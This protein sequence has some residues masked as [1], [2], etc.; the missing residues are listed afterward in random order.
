M[1]ADPSC[2][3]DVRAAAMRQLADW[4]LEETAFATEL[5]LSELVTNA[6]RY[7][8]EPIRVRLIFDRS[9]ICE[10][11][12]GSSTAPRL[13]QAA[14]TDEGGRGLFLVA[15]LT[16]AW[17]TRYTAEERSSGPSSPP[18]SPST[19]TPRRGGPVGRPVHTAWPTCRTERHA[20]VGQGFIAGAR[21]EQS[22]T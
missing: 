9:L 6:I 22:V 8:R 7:G 15:Q 5:L 12:D 10:V 19:H 14:S 3:S 4:N 13:R 18:S 20:R 1:P 17:G 2:V 11:Y 16:Q 21:H